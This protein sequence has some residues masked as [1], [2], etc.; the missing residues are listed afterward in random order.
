MDQ[1]CG[2]IGLAMLGAAVLATG[3]LL[4]AAAPAAGHAVLIG[5]TPEDAETVDEPPT[6]I[7]LEFNEPV[8]G[9][10]TQ[11]A[12]LD[13]DENRYEIGDPEVDGAEV[14]QPVDALGPGGYQVSYRVGSADGHPISGTIEFTVA[15]AAAAPTPTATSATTSP[16]TPSPTSD[17]ANADAEPT[18]DPVM[19]DS[20]EETAGADDDSPL[21]WPATAAAVLV[22]GAAAFMLVRR[23]PGSD[24]GQ[25]EVDTGR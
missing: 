7:V 13:A 16:A 6:E 23:R 2:R 5:S 14:T 19:E 22:A 12:V 21:L 3:G 4:V 17:V 8:H 24:P 18:D 15:E 11:V 25:A 20:T 1:G 9:E 10:F